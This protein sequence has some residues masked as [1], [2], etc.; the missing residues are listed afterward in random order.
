MIEN[1]FFSSTPSSQWDFPNYLRKTHLTVNKET[2]RGLKMI[3]NDYHT[4]LDE[5]LRQPLDNMTKLYVGRLKKL[6]KASMYGTLYSLMKFIYG[7]Y[8]LND[9]QL[10]EYA[11]ESETIT[12]STVVNVT[13]GGNSQVQV[14]D[15]NQQINR[16]NVGLST[17]PINP[18]QFRESAFGA[19]SKTVCVNL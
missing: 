15:N 13:V 7:M 6:Y 11:A 12:D 1:S 9:K 18:I 5:L 17:R 19:A 16:P 14:G 8:Q 4:D 3:Y 10:Q 2:L